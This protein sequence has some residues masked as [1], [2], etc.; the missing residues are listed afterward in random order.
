[1]EWKFGIWFSNHFAGNQQ[2]L[3]II[4]ETWA[5]TRAL[6]FRPTA[7]HTLLTFHQ[8]K[9]QYRV[10]LVP[11]RDPECPTKY[12]LAILIDV[13]G[14]TWNAIPSFTIQRLVGSMPRRLGACRADYTCW[15]SGL[16]ANKFRPRTRTSVKMK[17]TFNNRKNDGHFPH[18]SRLWSVLQEYSYKIHASRCIKTL[19]RACR[20]CAHEHV[21]YTTGKRKHESHFPYHSRLISLTRSVC[22]SVYQTLSSAGRR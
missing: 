7:L 8:E 15:M 17:A 13:L 20:R 19:S 5:N 12:S 2:R 1:M 21:G 16:P 6:L 14:Q 18:H 10:V 4:M 22:L 3:P 9:C 11:P